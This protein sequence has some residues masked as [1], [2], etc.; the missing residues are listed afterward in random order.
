MHPLYRTKVTLFAMSV[1]AC[2][3]FANA[4]AQASAGGCVIAKARLGLA[5]QQYQS[6]CLRYVNGQPTIICSDAR[7]SY[8]VYRVNGLR[9]I[10]YAVCGR[11]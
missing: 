7:L 5:I 1:A 4:P 10:A 6:E 3:A 2:L 11:P 8:W 9:A